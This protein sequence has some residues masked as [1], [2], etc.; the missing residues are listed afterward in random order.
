[1]PLLVGDAN[2]PE[3]EV[4]RAGSADNE[5]EEEPTV[6][7]F[8][9]A[10]LL[11]EEVGDER[12]PELTTLLAVTEA[13]LVVVLCAGKMECE[14]IGLM[15]DELAVVDEVGF[16]KK[17]S[18]FLG[19]ERKIPSSLDESLS[20]LTIGFGRVRFST[21]ANGSTTAFAPVSRDLVVDV[22]IPRIASSSSSFEPPL[23]VPPDG[24][25]PPV[26]DGRSS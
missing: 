13:A 16:E 23:F 4:V 25:I 9:P 22:P 6:R 10:A 26:V 12:V 14:S 3:E 2:R 17:E 21:S 19:L 5:E 7:D 1:V 18:F 15:V 20:K 24:S 8:A 11:A